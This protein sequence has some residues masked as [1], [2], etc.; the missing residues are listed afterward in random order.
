VQI[1]KRAMVISNCQ[2]LPIAAWLSTYSAN[3]VFDC[4]G[5][6]LLAPA[7]RPGLIAEF[8]AK[9]KAEFNLIIAAP[10]TEEFS[11]L[12][13]TKIDSTFEGIPVVKISNI[14]FSGLHPD[15][16]YIGGLSQRIVGPLVDYHSRI[17][18]FGFLNGLPLEDTEALYC[19]KTYQAVGYYDEFAASMKAIRDRDKDV[20]VPVSAMLEYL[21]PKAVCL[22]SVNHPSSAL[23]SPYCNDIVRYLERRGL[24]LH[25]GL[26]ADSFVCAESLAGNAI[27]PIYPEI[28]AHHGMAS[29]GSY[30]FKAVG[31]RVNPM[32]LPTFLAAEFGAFQNVG[33]E[34][35]AQ[36]VTGKQIMERFSML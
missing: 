27:F 14:Y 24:G 6:H 21:L 9:T 29:L 36:T 17:A 25:S 35:L 22:F 26:P 20:D 31:S 16:T 12:A 28:A 30:A 4:W 23:L 10:L 34:T 33:A 8:V 11:D 32:N 3:T 7:E 18:L 15:L 13:A 2:C 5:V 19:H 1:P